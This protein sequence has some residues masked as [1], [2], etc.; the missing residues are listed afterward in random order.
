MKGSLGE[1]SHLQEDVMKIRSLYITTAVACVLGG[2]SPVAAQSLS[3]AVGTDVISQMGAFQTGNWVNRAINIGEIDASVNI[4]AFPNLET[5]DISH[6]VRDIGDTT[7]ARTEVSYVTGNVAGTLNVS[8]S[9]AHSVINTFTESRTVIGGAV[10]GSSAEIK[11]VAA[12]AINTGHIAA[13]ASSDSATTSGSFD[14]S[15]EDLTYLDGEVSSATAS[16]TNTS[17]EAFAGDGVYASLGGASLSS[18]FQSSM[19]SS[20]IATGV[21]AVNEA[22]NNASINGSVSIVA[23]GTDLAGISTLAAGA[24]NTGSLS[25]G[26]DGAALNSAINGGN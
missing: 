18:S 13:A 4:T 24:L 19:S 3:D 15:L 17:A 10:V 16:T 8:D 14:G 1:L 26:F 22:F 25:L 2:I 20:N 7:A 23:N 9:T 6:D 12:G 21:Y 5:V 11:T